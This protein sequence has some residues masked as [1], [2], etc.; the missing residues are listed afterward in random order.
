[1]TVQN[2]LSKELSD[3]INIEWYN[4]YKCHNVSNVQNSCPEWIE[5]W[6]HLYTC[7]QLMDMDS[8]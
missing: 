3:D 1:M 7:K 5:L 2:M 8:K 4:K 6:K